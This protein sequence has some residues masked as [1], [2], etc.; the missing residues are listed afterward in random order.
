MNC[1]CGLNTVEVYETTAMLRQRN[2]VGK[3]RLNESAF[4]AGGNVSSE[5]VSERG[6]P[7]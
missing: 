6:K 5:S 7:A 1:T 3:L 2:L 4:K